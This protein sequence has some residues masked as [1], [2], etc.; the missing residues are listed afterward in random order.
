VLRLEGAAEA[1]WEVRCEPGLLLIPADAGM[2]LL[3]ALV[4]EAAVLALTCAEAGSFA[5]PADTQALAGA[6]GA[7]AA[8]P[9][10]E[11]ALGGLLLFKL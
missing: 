1:A 2:L 11:R 4:M 8:N 5:P 6:T 3:E 9:A 7:G 10:I